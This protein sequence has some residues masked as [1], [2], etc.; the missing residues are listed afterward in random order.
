MHNCRALYQELITWV[1][2]ETMQAPTVLRD[3]SRAFFDDLCEELSAIPKT[4]WMVAE[5]LACG[6]LAAPRHG[7]R[8]GRDRER[9]AAAH[10]SKHLVAMAWQ[11]VQRGREGAAATAAARTA[12]ASCGAHACLNTP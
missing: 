11:H 3:H 8:Y 7:R 6:L 12:S 1:R 4:K 9:G 5:D 10:V 2:P